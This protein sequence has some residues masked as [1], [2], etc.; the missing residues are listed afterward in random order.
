[1]RSP[2]KHTSTL[3]GTI[4]VFALF[5][6]LVGAMVLFGWAQM[7]A[8]A[9]VYP[10]TAAE[11]VKNRIALENARALARQFLLTELPA[12]T[13]ANIDAALTDDWGGF[14]INGSIGFWTNTNY[15]AGNPFSPFGNRSFV[16]TNLATLSNGSQ[17]IV[18]R[19][20]IKSRSPLL[21][22]YPLAQHL[23][24]APIVATWAPTTNVYY[25]ET[26]GFSGA[27]QIPFSSGTTETG[28]GATNGYLGYFASPISTFSVTNGTAV[29]GMAYPTNTLATNNRIYIPPSYTNG[30]NVSNNF[31]GA[32]ISAT[33]STTQGASVLRYDLPSQLTNSFLVSYLV[34]TVSTNTVTNVSTSTNVITTGTNYIWNSRHTRIIGTNYT[35]TTNYSYTTNTYLTNY[36]ATNRYTDSYTSSSITNLTIVGS[37]ATNTLHIV[38]PSNCTSLTNIVLSGTINARK[39]YINNQSTTGLTLQTATLDTSYDWWLGATFR[40]PLTIIAP[41]GG[42]RKLTVTGGF[43]SDQSINLNSGNLSLAPA[44]NATNTTADPIELISDR[45]LWIEDGRNR[46]P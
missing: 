40:S 42:G 24:A 22:G 44:P 43:R 23:S 26:I 34:T 16:I 46:T 45:V 35:Y 9:S 36:Y 30:T 25:N 12:G 10:D 29:T 4:L 20:F 5:I 19:I 13:N 6:V 7:L 17:T 14:S 18:Q 31:T 27:P 2:S 32:K 15:V 37:T 33:L 21:A 11:G 3:K 39:I 1:M 8:T 28:T 38:I 41:T